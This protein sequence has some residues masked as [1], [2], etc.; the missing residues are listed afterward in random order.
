MSV[1]FMDAAPFWA[2]ASWVM[3]LCAHALRQPRIRRLIGHDDGSGGG[4]GM[5]TLLLLPAPLAGLALCVA[6]DAAIGVLYWFGT[7]SLA[8]VVT[9]LGLAFIQ[10]R[11]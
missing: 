10:V 5:I 3:A 11:R 4:A 6:A 9:A 1:L 7:L 2:F 8:G